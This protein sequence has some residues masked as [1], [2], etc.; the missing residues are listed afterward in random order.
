M[1]KNKAVTKKS[2]DSSSVQEGDEKAQQTFCS[3]K[4]DTGSC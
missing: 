2:A 4:F 1:Q 3:E